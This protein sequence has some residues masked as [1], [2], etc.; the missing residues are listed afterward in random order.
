MANDIREWSSDYFISKIGPHLV[1]L[2]V[3]Q[4]FWDAIL[5]WFRKSSE[6]L[7]GSWQEYCSIA[8]V[9]VQQQCGE[10]MPTIEEPNLPDKQPWSPCKH[11]GGTREC[12]SCKMPVDVGGMK[13]A[14]GMFEEHRGFVISRLD[15]ELPAYIGGRSDR[16]YAKFANVEQEVW[17]N[18][19]G[20]IESFTPNPTLVKD[21][22]FAWLT[23]VVHNTVNDHFK[24]QFRAK[25]GPR[26]ETPFDSDKHDLANPDSPRSVPAV[27]TAVPVKAENDDSKVRFDASGVPYRK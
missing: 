9:R 7:A 4:R 1:R 25:R 23:V 5:K 27:R 26:K 8:D 10:Y 18:I 15:K 2:E 6:W 19:A 13:R 12:D 24:H 21:G 22:V 3:P 11:F 16:A 17:Q 20:R 14:Q